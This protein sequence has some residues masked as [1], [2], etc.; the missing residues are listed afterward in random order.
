MKQTK[1]QFRAFF[2]IAIFLFSA[3]AQGQGNLL[4]TPKRIMFD[5]SRRSQEL[6]LANTG[7]DSAT[8][9]ISF[10][11]YRMKN[12]GGFEPI[13]VPDSAQRFADK[14]LR[15]YPRTVTLAPNEAQSIKIQLVNQDK[16]EPGEYRS[17]LYL[18]SMAKPTPLGEKQQA[19][20]SDSSLSVKLTPVFGI[21]LAVI[22]RKGENNAVASITDMKHG[23]DS[24]GHSV[25]FTINRQ[26]DMSLYGDIVVNHIAEDGAETRVSQVKGI[27]VYTPTTHRRMTV[28]ASKEKNIDFSK[29]KLRV[30][31]IDQSN[32]TSKYAEEEIE[33]KGQFFTGK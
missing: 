17:H 22:I 25:S 21:S 20:K 1:L 24:L 29:G 26:G 12:D 27:A 6:N 8:Y 14:F 31:Y 11:Q 18:R 32:K 7:K 13:T 33:L 23:G 5:G 28:A 30:T 15:Y 4:V 16:L 2:A 9:V 19:K 3:V 10:M